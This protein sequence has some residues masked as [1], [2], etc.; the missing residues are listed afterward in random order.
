MQDLHWRYNFN[1]TE[2]DFVENNPNQHYEPL[3]KHVHVPTLV[4]DINLVQTQKLQQ[5]VTDVL[6]R[7]SASQIKFDQIIFDGTQ[8]PF[9][10]YRAK[11]ATL[12]AFTQHKG[13]PC[14][15]SLSQFDLGTHTHL[16]EINY[17]SWLF[18]FKKQSLPAWND[19][20]R[21]HAFSCLNRNPTFHRLVLYTLIKQ[22]E[23]LDNFI[24]SFYDQCPYQGHKITAYQYRG[25]EKLVGDKLAQQCI[26]NIQD[27]PISW[28]GET[29]GNN[30]HSIAH[31]AYQD[32]W[33]NI[34]TETSALVSFTSEKIWKPIAAGQ[35]FLVMG[36]PGTCAWLK[37]LGFY[38]FDDAYDSK[39]NFGSRAELLVEQISNHASDT[40][41]WWQANK[42][43]IEHNYHWFKSGNVEKT[44]LDPIVN[45]LNHK[46]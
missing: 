31:P 21:T 28:A 40:K 38:T 6:D 42:F 23:L 35:L 46:Y 44:L 34:V 27:F 12:E 5:Y 11:V 1:T 14:Y 37:K 45:Q 2:F 3:L 33:C 18:V 36:S 41:A 13:I 29:L 8:D 32:A 19:R 39:Q 26:D 4:I 16:K 10:D 7:A 24:Y 22:Q 20:P 25:L 15:L 30:D 17:P 9:V 43:Q